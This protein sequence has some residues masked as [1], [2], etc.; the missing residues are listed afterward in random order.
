MSGD[1][2]RDECYTLPS[3][4]YTSA[5]IFEEEVAT[6][7]GNSWMYVGHISSL[8][9]AG[10]FA[11]ARIAGE[12]ILLV[13]DG[14]GAVRAFYNVCSHRAHR[15]VTPGTSGRRPTL[16]CPN[17]AWSYKLDGTL[18]KARKTDDQPPFDPIKYGLKQVRL[19]NFNGLLF[20]NLNPHAAPLF[21]ALGNAGLKDAI[22]GS[23]L[24]MERME[25]ESSVEK[26]V[27]ANWKCLVD[28]YLECYHCDTAHKDFV[29]MVDMNQYTTQI[30]P[31]HVYNSSPCRPQNSAYEFS[32]L[33]KCS[34]RTSRRVPLPR[35][36]LC[37]AARGLAAHTR[38]NAFGR[39][40]GHPLLLA[41]AQHGRVLGAGPAEHERAAVHPSQLVAVAASCA[42]L[43]C[44]GG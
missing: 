4:A 29:S 13:R 43:L 33:D 16:L 34:V 19:E 10:S 25:L 15:I 8:P 36:A 9:A 21:D 40:A 12:E 1:A 30:G 7:F 39:C 35:D 31:R 26:E 11:T 5:A 14:F 41:M 20:G 22:S 28:N 38:M 27:A 3:Q 24:E 32:A 23:I 17:H 2:R 37:V 42:P 18:L 44:A 6:I